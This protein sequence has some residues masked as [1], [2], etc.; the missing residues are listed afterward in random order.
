MGN[1]SRSASARRPPYRTTTM[2]PCRQTLLPGAVVEDAR[3]GRGHVA[4]AG[5]LRLPD[6]R[7]E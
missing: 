7:G 3:G 6:P 2:C 4:R 5:E 1:G